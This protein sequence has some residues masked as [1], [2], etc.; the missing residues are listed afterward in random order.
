[1][2][3][4]MGQT[5]AAIVT[6]SGWVA[7]TAGRRWR[8]TWQPA[9]LPPASDA[10][11]QESSAVRGTV[12]FLPPLG[13]ELNHTRPLMAAA[14]RALAATGW[15]VHC[16]DP[17]GTG[18]SDGDFADASLANWAEDFAADA[19]EAATRGPWTLW[20]ARQGALLLPALWQA[21]QRRGVPLPLGLASWNPVVQGSAVLTQW[22]RLAALGT[23]AAVAPLGVD[24]LRQQLADGAGK[25]K[26]FFF[27]HRPLEYVQISKR[28][29]PNTIR[30]ASR[31]SKRAV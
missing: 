14:A 7:G 31:G 24:A 25:L 8:T 5:R 4:T 19:A 11:G 10:H 20:V 29:A 12:L 23:H 13:D 9:L 15:T 26:K 21:L 27:S 1:M 30:D 6:T 22:L 18:D 2:A 28:P 3:P 17:A 16:T